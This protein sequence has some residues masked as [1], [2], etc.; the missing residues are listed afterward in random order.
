MR[1][2]LYTGLLFI[3]IP[4]FIVTLFFSQNNKNDDTK[5][6]DSEL[7]SDIKVRIKREDL[8]KIEVIELEKICGWC[9]SRRNACY[10]SY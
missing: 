9:S 8:N 1:Q 5:E 4:F 7:N 3:L 10:L 6:I 2:I